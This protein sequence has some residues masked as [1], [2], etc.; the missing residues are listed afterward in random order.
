MAYNLY[1]EF[2]IEQHKKT[3]I[4]YLEVVIDENGRIMYAVPSHQ[5][6]LIA[7][8]CEKLNV[9]REE[10]NAMCPQE[11]YFDFMTWLCKMS[12]ACAVWENQVMR[13]KFTA[14][15]IKALKR[16]KDEGLYLGEIPRID[17]GFDIE[18][19]DWCELKEV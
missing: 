10:L 15:Q 12:G 7:L 9:T 1:S 5:E 13:D 16:L 8:A 3:F 11:Y 4:H 2:D 14:E 6:K 19:P 18:K 17:I